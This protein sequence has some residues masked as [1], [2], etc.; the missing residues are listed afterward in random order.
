MK[1]KNRKI[2]IFLFFLVFAFAFLS[3]ERGFA[4][5]TAQNSLVDSTD[6]EVRGVWV[7]EL[8]NSGKVATIVNNI[9]SANLNT[10]FVV[11][12]PI[13][14]NNG[15]SPKKQFASFVK[16]AHRNNLSVHIWIP[17]MYRKKDGTQADFRSAKERKAQ[18]KWA[19]KL[20]KKYKRYADGIHFDYIRYYDWE[21]VNKDQKMDAV[22]QAVREMTSAVRKKYK[23]MFVTA[24][25]VSATPTWANFS[26]EDIPDWFRDWY[27]ANPGNVYETSYS[28]PTVPNHMKYQQDPVTWIRESNLDAVM[29]MQYA[30]SDTAWN[31]EADSWRSFLAYS[32]KEPSRILMGIGWL[33]EE[34]HPEWGYDAAGV[35]RKISYGRSLGYKGFVIYELNGSARDSEL[36]NVL[37][38]DSAENN[39]NAP[40]ESSAATCLG[41]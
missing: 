36:V 4:R 22:S 1:K 35:A 30:T 19:L 24:T 39:S 5:K 29:P 40:F 21:N 3:A 31:Q 17:N 9:R 41:K 2:F 12:P 6:C 26:A 7:D 32:G 18:K 15:W 8:D 33:E 37:T 25:T 23:N 14:S 38:T 13:G 10:V 28:F 20:L 34:G 16:L 27:S 11:S